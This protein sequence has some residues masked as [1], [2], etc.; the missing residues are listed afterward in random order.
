MIVTVHLHTILQLQ[1][2]DGPIR[3]LELNLPEGSNLQDIL[4]QLQMPLKLEDILLVVNTQTARPEQILY[5]GDE[6]HLIP[7]LS[8]GGN[9]IPLPVFR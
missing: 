2:P 3:R 4:N 9:G 6:V 5:D 1:T 7:A 8:G